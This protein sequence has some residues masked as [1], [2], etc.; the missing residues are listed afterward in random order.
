MN[1]RN[2]TLGILLLMV[3]FGIGVNRWLALGQSRLS[4]HISTPD[5]LTQAVSL[6]GVM[7][8]A[9]DGILYRFE[10]G[11][12]SRVHLP[13][14]GY[15][16]QPSQDGSNIIVV[17]RQLDYSDAYV[18]NPV[19]G[20]LQYQ[21]T[22]NEG[23]VPVNPNNI[24]ENYWIFWPH[25]FP[26]T[27]TL[28]ASTDYPKSGYKVDFSIWQDPLTHFTPQTSPA[29]VD[30]WT[31]PNNYTGGDTTPT[32]L[33]NGGILFSHYSLNDINGNEEILSVIG[34]QPNAPAQTTY[35]TQPSQDCS[36]PNVS[37]DQS[38]VV[39]ICTDSSS[40]T[41]ELVNVETAPLL[42]GGAALGPMH[43]VVS[44]CLCAYPTWSPDSK[45]I[46]YLAPNGRTG[47]FQLWWVKKPQ[48]VHV[49]APTLVT[50]QQSL[51]VNFDAT[52]PPLWLPS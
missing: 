7:Y 42:Q 20:K 23:P 24:Q 5:A 29:S 10:N 4:I 52:S 17:N 38:Q 2:S 13:T 6:P 41:A 35:L 37:P 49:A 46:V 31:I 26:G 9:Q 15:W 16:M 39:M 18:A 14:N 3:L 48:A 30:Q 27:Q 44:Q 22:H 47:P 25:I 40:N 51:S 11:R 50:D 21:I 28:I 43:T 34:Y 33:A 36:Q 45:S 1:K 19:T 32:P 12:F 8:L